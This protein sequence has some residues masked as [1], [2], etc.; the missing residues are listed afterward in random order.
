MSKEEGT[1]NEDARSK[2]NARPTARS[3]RQ[4]R[5]GR[6]AKECEG[7]REEHDQV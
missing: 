6:D 2:E 1:P 3:L 7:G 5:R 4:G